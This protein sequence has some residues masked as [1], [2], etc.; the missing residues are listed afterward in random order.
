MDNL[1]LTSLQLCVQ[2]VQNQK[3]I[4]VKDLQNSKYTQG[5]IQK[6]FGGCDLD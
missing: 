4:T 3:K 2:D 1:G 6:N 5:R